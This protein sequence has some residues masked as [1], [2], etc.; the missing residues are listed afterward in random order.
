MVDSVAL[1]AARLTEA[2]AL[3]DMA[4]ALDRARSVAALGPEIASAAAESALGRAVELLWQRGWQPGE[5]VTAVSRPLTA[6][7]TR[8]VAAQCARYPEPRLHPVW[9]TQLTELAAGPL[10]M[11]SIEKSLHQVVALI[12]ELMALPQLPMLVPGPTD[13]AAATAT[14]GVDR[15][16]L[17]RVRGLLAKA[18]STAFPAEAE[19]LS[20]KA[21]ELMS[22]YAFEQAVVTAAEPQEAAARRLW[23]RGPYLTP[24]AQLVDA[25]AS[26]N[27]CRTVFYPRLGCV[28]LVGHETDLEITD[29]LA[30]SLLVQSTRA[31]THAAGSGRAYRHAFLVAYAHRVRQRLTEAGDQVRPR[32]TELVPVLAARQ[33]AVDSTFTTLFPGVRTRRT[34]ATDPAGWGA[35]IAAADL[36]DLHP[37]RRVAG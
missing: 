14:A 24:K 36:A 5:V 33:Q 35:G 26:A 30:T 32:S 29:L 27:R 15:R 8:A 2:A 10:L 31:L 13:P 18:E 28:G 12:A 20:A 7:A 17:A 9:R 23:L 25:V 19:A 3:G 37:H 6:L 34:T 22:R 4:A 1:L 16:V 21:Q 11:G